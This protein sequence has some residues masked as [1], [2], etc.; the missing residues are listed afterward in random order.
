MSGKILMLYIKCF[1]KNRAFKITAHTM[2]HA[3]K[4]WIFFICFKKFLE[5]KIQHQMMQ[6]LNDSEI[7]ECIGVFRMWEEGWGVTSSLTPHIF[8]VPCKIKNTV[9]ENL[10]IKI[11]CDGK[12]FLKDL[13]RILMRKTLFF[14]AK[15]YC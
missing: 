7:T 13:S 2:L 9:T 10:K 3:L 1:C 14:I 12:C 11:L 8:Y 5:G 6:F 4:H 15:N